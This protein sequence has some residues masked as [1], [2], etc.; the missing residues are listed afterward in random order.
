VGTDWRR[1]WA[2]SVVFAVLA[3]LSEGLPQPA[4]AGVVVLAWLTAGA[5]FLVGAADLIDRSAP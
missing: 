4:A 5:L 2:G 3:L 1:A